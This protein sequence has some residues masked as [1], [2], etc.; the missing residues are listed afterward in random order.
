MAKRK[1][2]ILSFSYI[3]AFEIIRIIDDAYVFQQQ[4]Q[5]KVDSISDNIE[6]SHTNVR[7]ATIKLG[8]VRIQ[9]GTPVLFVNSLYLFRW[10]SYFPSYH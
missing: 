7:E 9:F 1:W 8:Q 3:L 5:E 4:Q 10:I 2:P 6:K